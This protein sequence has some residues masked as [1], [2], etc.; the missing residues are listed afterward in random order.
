M[1]E[2]RASEWFRGY[3]KEEVMNELL[4]NEPHL[5][6]QEEE[7]EELVRPETDRNCPEKDFT[8]RLIST[9]YS[10]PRIKDIEDALSVVEP[11]TESAHQMV[12]MS[13]AP[14][15]ERDLSKM[16][17]RYTLKVKNSGNG[18]GDDGYKW[19]KY[20]QKS[21]KNSPNP[22]SY[23][24]CTNTR[25]NAKK[26]VERSIDDPDTFIIT[27]EGLHL[28]F[29]YPF[30]LPDKAHRPIKKPKPSTPE[31]HQAQETQPSVQ[32]HKA[33]EE[34]S[35]RFLSEEELFPAL[36]HR[37]QRQGLLE[38]VVAPAIRNIPAKDPVSDS[39]SSSSSSSGRSLSPPSSAMARS[40]NLS[41]FY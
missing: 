19:R 8:N 26:Q 3:E 23:Y 28:H 40:P 41:P 27:Y 22:R 12:S 21:I 31:A 7:E 24:K 1:E 11:R 37:R 2:Q 14:L 34:A 36:D 25:C 32:A 9:L 39:C 33:Q 13:R 10:G 15:L 16:E 38:D 29:T 5:L 17:H 35:R 30:F 6:L 18:M 4:A 20:G